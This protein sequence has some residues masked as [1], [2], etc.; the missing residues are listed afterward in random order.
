MI[1]R[2]K[3]KVLVTQLRPTLCDSMDC[4]LPGSSLHGLLW[5]EPRRLQWGGEPFPS[6]RD[7][8]DPGIRPT[9]PA[10]QAYSL[11]SEPAG[12]TPKFQGYFCESLFL[13]PDRQTESKR[14]YF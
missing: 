12:I 4:S 6:P 8:P 14:N 1:C 13:S 9:S 3:V 10:L 5:T 2:M 7:F 11:P